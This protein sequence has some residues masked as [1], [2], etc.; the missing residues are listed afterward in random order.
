MLAPDH[1]SA[2]LHCGY[3]NPV[4]PERVKAYGSACNVNYG[5]NCTHFVKVYLIQRLVMNLS[6]CLGNLP[7]NL[8]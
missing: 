3:I 5:V 7:E 2:E 4:N 1:P 6:F 8:H